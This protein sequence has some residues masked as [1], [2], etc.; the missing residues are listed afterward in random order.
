MEK[1][2]CEIKKLLVIWP[3]PS[4]L[5]KNVHSINSERK[6]FSFLITDEVIEACCQEKLVYF[7]EGKILHLNGDFQKNR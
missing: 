3:D 2:S 5:Y 6:L 1:I 4:F 7:G